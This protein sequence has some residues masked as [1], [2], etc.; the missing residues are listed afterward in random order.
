MVRF[1]TS[2]PWKAVPPTS[3]RKAA[4]SGDTYTVTFTRKLAEANRLGRRQTVPFGVAIHA[5]HAVGRFHHISFGYMLG[6]GAEGDM[7][8]VKQ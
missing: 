1:P 2:A 3:R 6:I 4:K 5:D 7:K 8:A